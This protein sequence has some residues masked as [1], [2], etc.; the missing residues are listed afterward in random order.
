MKC[1]KVCKE[2][3]VVCPIKDCRSWINYKKDMNCLYESIE[4]N[5]NMTLRQV[6]ERIGVSFVRIKQI[7]EKALKKLGKMVKRDTI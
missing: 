4:K 1:L 3:N 7:E 2:L 6:S 5:G